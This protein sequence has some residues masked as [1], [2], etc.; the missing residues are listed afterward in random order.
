MPLLL[1]LF[2]CFVFSFSVGIQNQRTNGP[3]NTHLISWPSKTQNIKNRKIY[4]K[5]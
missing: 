4:G 1:L 5:K 3:V 2:F